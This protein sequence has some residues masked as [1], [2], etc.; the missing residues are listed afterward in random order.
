VSEFQAEAPQATASEGLAQS[1]Y[2]AVRAGFE[3][4]TNLP[5]SQHAS[6]IGGHTL[7]IIDLRGM[8]APEFHYS[9]TSDNYRTAFKAS[10]KGLLFF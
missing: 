4:A 1:P 5:M 7:C 10:P 2:V 9:L 6:Q 8:D 3:P